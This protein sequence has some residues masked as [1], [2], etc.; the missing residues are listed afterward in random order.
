MKAPA[1]PPREDPAL[2]TKVVPSSAPE[3]SNISL[4]V[5]LLKVN[6]LIKNGPQFVD[7]LSGGGCCNNTKPVRFI[8]S[9]TEGSEQV[10]LD[11]VDSDEQRNSVVHYPILA[12]PTSQLI[13]KIYMC[14]Q[15]DNPYM[16]RVALLGEIVDYFM[17]FSRF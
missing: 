13:P 17:F 1:I 12:D 11:H 9:S 6:L 8:S 7:E 14:F 2:E 4:S 15:C 3:T 16:A 5:N 10:V